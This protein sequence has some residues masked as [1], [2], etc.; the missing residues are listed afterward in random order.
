MEHAGALEVVGVGVCLGAG[1]VLGAAGVPVLL[2]IVAVVAD[3]WAGID[4]EQRQVVTGVA[5]RDP[6]GVVPVR[7]DPHR[8][9]LV[10]VDLSLY[11]VAV[12]MIL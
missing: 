8:V 7:H 10:V 3:T 2:V 4:E 11:I 9:Q 1:G 6:L 5:H 12:L